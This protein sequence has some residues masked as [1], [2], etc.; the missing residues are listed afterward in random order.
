MLHRILPLFIL[1]VLLTGCLPVDSLNPWYSSKDLVFD[2]AL[3]GDWK[4]L[5]GKSGLS[6]VKMIDGKGPNSYSLEVTEDS[7]FKIKCRGRLFEIEGHRFLDV[8]PEDWEA[9]TETYPLRMTPARQGAKIEPNLLRLGS[10]SYMVFSSSPGSG[11][12]TNF[13]AKLQPAHWIFRM[14]LNG[15]KLKLAS[16]DDDNLRALIEPGTIHIGNTIF[17]EGKNKSLVLTAETKDL[18][19]LVLDH[20]DDETVFT[21]QGDELERQPE[22]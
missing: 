13:K 22:K 20:V 3:L 5:D 10:A 14:R 1:I 21:I 4:A 7:G 6:F 11:N 15:K 17:G 16:I 8:V 9:R 12:T 2:Q 18:Q 19:R